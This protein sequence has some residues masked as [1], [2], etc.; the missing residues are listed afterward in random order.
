M[1]DQ[2]WILQQVLLIN[3]EKVPT[4]QMK[5]LLLLWVL[6]RERTNAFW[7]YK[8]RMMRS[9]RKNIPMCL[10][11]LIV[12]SRNVFLYCNYCMYIVDMTCFQCSHFI[13][14]NETNL[15]LLFCIIFIR[16]M[17]SNNYRKRLI[18]PNNLPIT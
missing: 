9:K 13:S 7:L 18:T 12:F 1:L 6:L 3:W 16:F 4:Y 5:N 15:P 2:R 10:E 17:I 14:A 11:S 8:R